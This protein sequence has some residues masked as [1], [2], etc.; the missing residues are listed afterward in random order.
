[1]TNKKTTNPPRLASR[2]DTI[3][4]V[5][6]SVVIIG[7]ALGVTYYTVNSSFQLGKASQ[8]R[9]FAVDVLNTQIERLKALIDTEPELVFDPDTVTNEIIFDPVS[10]T[11]PL[12]L[13]PPP[14]IGQYWGPEFCLKHDDTD[15]TRDPLPVI[16]VETTPANCSG[17]QNTGFPVAI[18]EPVIA[19]RYLHENP[20][21]EVP[22][23]SGNF[24][25]RNRFEIKI[26]WTRTNTDR[27]IELFYYFRSHPFQF[28]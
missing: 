6:I 22:P 13:T 23:G 2:G 19:I 20:A 5:L 16:L 25:D 9:G 15:T 8:E 11:F 4:S 1:M 3:L 12:T 21:S 10:D 27:R 17:P 24:N 28:F 7:S 26:T 18:A 14:G